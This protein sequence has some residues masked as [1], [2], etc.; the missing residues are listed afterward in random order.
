MTTETEA[1]NEVYTQFMTQWGTTTPYTF[2]NEG[3][4]PPT[5]AAWVRLSV[6]E[7]AG[8]Q[9]T[10]GRV[11]NRKYLRE[12]QAVLQIFTPKDTGKL[13]SQEL[14]RLFRTIF[15]GARYSGL[16]F[17]DATWNTVGHD[18]VFD[19]VNAEVNFDYQEIK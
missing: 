18:G 5:A 7:L 12:N 6:I 10:L 2:E 15:E 11:S 13:R 16:R 4:T 8:G 17:Y 1:L 14:V 19:Q 9:Q 3:F